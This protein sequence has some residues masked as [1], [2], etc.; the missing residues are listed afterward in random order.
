MLHISLYGITTKNFIKEIYNYIYKMNKKM[1][2]L[3]YKIYIL[4]YKINVVYVIRYLKY[5]R[6][7]IEDYI[8]NTEGI[9]KTLAYKKYKEEIIY[10]IYNCKEFMK[11][12]YTTI[13]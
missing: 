13:N 2:I 12:L 7:L 11:K 1:I 8:D 5:T 9:K 3:I 4:I 6:K 10:I